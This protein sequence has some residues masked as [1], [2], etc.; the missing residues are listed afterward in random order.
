MTDITTRLAE[1]KAVAEKATPGPWEVVSNRWTRDGADVIGDYI[2]TAEGRAVRTDKWKERNPQVAD[3]NE[4]REE[5]RTITVT[6]SATEYRWLAW[7]ILMGRDRVE[8][9]EQALALA[10]AGKSINAAWSSTDG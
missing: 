9:S 4:E 5:N 7:A 2:C 1:L 3:K 10:S 8:S 6:L